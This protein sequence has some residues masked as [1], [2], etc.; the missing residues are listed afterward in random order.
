M[1]ILTSQYYIRKW[2]NNSGPSLYPVPHRK[3]IGAFLGQDPLSS[4]CIILLTNRLANKQ[5]DTGEN[6]TSLVGWR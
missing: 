5:L 4:F 1:K 2:E 6:K 3:L